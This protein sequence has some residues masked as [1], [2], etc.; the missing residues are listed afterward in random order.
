MKRMALLALPLGLFA[1]AAMAQDTTLPLIE[2]GD[3]SGN[4]SLA[5]LQTQWPDL[6]AEGFAGIDANGDGAVDPAELQ[7]AVDNGVVTLP[8]SAG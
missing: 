7:A 2:D 1:G 6:T 4:W 8:G 5:E 3:A